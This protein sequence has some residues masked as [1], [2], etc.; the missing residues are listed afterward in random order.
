MA[1]SSA[2]SAPPATGAS[3]GLRHAPASVLARRAFSDARVRTIAFGYLFA[4][5]AY[6][7]PAGYRSAYPTL[8]DRLAFAHGFAA[9]D[10][11]RLLYGYPYDPVTVAGYCAWRVAGTLAVAAALFGVLAAVR[12][13]RSEEDAGRTEL[14]L[15]GA[16]G[17]ATVYASAMAAIAAGVL[18]LWLAEFAGS[19]AGGLPV[20]GSAYMALSTASVAPVFVGLG[21]LTSQLAPTRRIALEL[22]CGLVGLFLL[23]LLGRRRFTGRQPLAGAHARSRRELPAGGAPV[24]RARVPGLRDRA[25]G[26]RRHRL[27]ARHHRVHLGSARLAARRA[28]M[29]REGRPVGHSPVSTTAETIDRR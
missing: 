11:L 14:I 2:L 23:L 13:L 22:G 7:Q 17:R 3:A 25:S 6:V 28:Q 26:E 1:A 15:A 12:A 29:A 20:G 8:A 10:A 19:V 4:I 9:T 5:Y 24:P 21:A 16:V 27:R 18:V